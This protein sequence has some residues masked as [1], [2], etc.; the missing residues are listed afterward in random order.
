MGLCAEGPLVRVEVA[1]HKDVLYKR[2]EP[3]LARLIIT[4]HVKPALEKG[5]DF[6]VPEYLS[7]HILPLDIPF[8]T[9]QEKVVLENAGHIDPEDITAYFARGGYSAFVDVIKN[10]TPQDVINIIKES[11]LRGRGGGGFPTGMRNNFV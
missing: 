2:M 7:E 3:V 11:G 4:E 1:G 9:K 10:K 6:T 8:F 5:E